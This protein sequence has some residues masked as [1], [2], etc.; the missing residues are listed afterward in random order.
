M[1]VICSRH[2]D[3]AG[4]AGGRNCDRQSNTRP[5]NQF[6]S[7]GAAQGC[8]S[9]RER[10]NSILRFVPSPEIAT[11]FS[12]KQIFRPLHGIILMQG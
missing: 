12:H 3:V 2:L 11:Q 6:V 7:C 1:G 9:D 10:W 8:I 4:I 5:E